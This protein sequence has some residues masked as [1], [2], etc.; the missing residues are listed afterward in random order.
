MEGTVFENSEVAMEV[1]NVFLTI[2]ERMN[3]SIIA[4][5]D[6]ISPEECKVF[7]RA[8]AHVMYEVFEK[9]VEP[10]CNRHPSLKPPGFDD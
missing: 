6:R 9:V 2:N 5:Q 4:T 7:K 10:I 8:V 3:E 1:L